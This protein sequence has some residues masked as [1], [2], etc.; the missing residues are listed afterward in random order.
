MY[1]LSQ[2]VRKNVKQII[3][4][5]EST[6]LNI[7][8]GTFYI[9]FPMPFDF[10]NTAISELGFETFS[11]P[12]VFVSPVYQ[13]INNKERFYAQDAKGVWHPIVFEKKGAE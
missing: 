4:T 10:T 3:L 8:E 1:P 13:D 5:S 6:T 9:A 7:R 11:L 12:K 2:L